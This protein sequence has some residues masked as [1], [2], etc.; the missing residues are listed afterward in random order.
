MPAWCAQVGR[1]RRSG[2]L[3]LDRFEMLDA[4]STWRDRPATWRC[5]STPHG[6]QEKRVTQKNTPP[7]L[8]GGGWGEGSGGMRPTTPPP[9]PL[10]QGEGEC[11]FATSA[12]YPD[13]HGATPAGCWYVGAHCQ[14]RD[15]GPPLRAGVGPVERRGGYRIGRRLSMTTQRSMTMQRSMTVQRIGRRA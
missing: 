1:S 8:E 4:V 7:P 14:R 3:P 2:A 5:R 11:L 13:A 10:P 9:S 15:A 12:A 6:R